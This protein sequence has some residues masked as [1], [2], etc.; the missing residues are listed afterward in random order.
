M[1]FS[2]ISLEEKERK[3]R[4]SYK[5]IYSP[6]FPRKYIGKGRIIFRSLWELRVMKWLDTNK[7]VLEWA[8]EP[9]RIA[10]VA[11]TDNKYHGYWPDFW[12]KMKTKDDKFI[13]VVLEV[14]P[15]KETIEPVPK[16]TVNGK[17]KKAYIHEVYTWS[18]NNAKWKAA[19]EYCK[20]RNWEFYKLT[21]NEIFDNNLYLRKR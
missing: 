10:Y 20:Q 5:G 12:A 2:R 15:F 13:E 4:R 16:K 17:T 6:I 7:N 19:E 8:S 11:P 1:G 3:T 21:E 9:F 14:K 18:I